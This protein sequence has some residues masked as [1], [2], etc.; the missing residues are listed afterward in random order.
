[1]TP[2][3]P[4]EFY[5]AITPV[6][7]EERGLTERFP[8]IIKMARRQQGRLTSTTLIHNQNGKAAARRLTSTILIHNQNGKAAARTAQSTTSTEYIRLSSIIKMARRL[9]G[10]TRARLPSIIKIA[11]RL[12][13]RHFL[14]DARAWGQFYSLNRYA[15]ALK[16]SEQYVLRTEYSFSYQPNHLA[17]ASLP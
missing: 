3:L 8:S 16:Q 1:M 4:P 11:R 12:Q 7:L 13:G 10:L 2:I 17:T 9:Q 6:R 15:G 14:F 5:A